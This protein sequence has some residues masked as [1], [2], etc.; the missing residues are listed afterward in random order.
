MSKIDYRSEVLKV[1]PD[2][3]YVYFEN[4][5]PNK[6]HIRLYEEGFPKSLGRGNGEQDAWKSAYEKLKKQGK[7]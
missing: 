2:A 7:I 5:I 4:S 6:H 1:Y 3:Y